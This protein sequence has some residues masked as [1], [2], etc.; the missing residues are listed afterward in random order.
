MIVQ[1]VV[2]RQHLAVTVTIFLLQ[3]PMP[4]SGVGIVRRSSSYMM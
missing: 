4:P 3:P 1:V 2:Q